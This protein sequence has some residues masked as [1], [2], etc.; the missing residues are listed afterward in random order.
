[1]FHSVSTFITVVVLAGGHADNS[2]I[3]TYTGI[4]FGS[5]FALACLIG[6]YVSKYLRERKSLSSYVIDFFDNSPLLQDYISFILI[7]SQ[8]N[9]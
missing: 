7:M 3:G 5:L 8:Q 4:A 6:C 2:M 9:L 1:M